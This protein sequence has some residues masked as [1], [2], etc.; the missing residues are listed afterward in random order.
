MWRSSYAAQGRL[1]ED[2][3]EVVCGNEEGH[4]IGGDWVLV[5]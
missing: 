5:N 4:E 3:Q 1:V 2:E